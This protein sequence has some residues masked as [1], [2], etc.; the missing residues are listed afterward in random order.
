MPVSS[1]NH[2]VMSMQTCNVPMAEACDDVGS[3]GAG[4][5]SHFHCQLNMTS[6]ITDYSSVGLIDL[7]APDYKYQFSSNVHIQ[8]LSTKPPLLS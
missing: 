8:T 2:D 4:L 3:G 5:F 6:L 1:G 7:P